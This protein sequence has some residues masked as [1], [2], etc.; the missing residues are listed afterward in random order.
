MFG[1]QR[2]IHAYQQ[3]LLKLEKYQGQ[4]DTI[5]PSHGSFPVY[6]DL[7]TKLYYGVENILAGKIKPE[8]MIIHNIPVIKYDIKVASFLMD[9]GDIKEK[10]DV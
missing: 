2:E 10:S 6:P 8:Y 5:Y 1:I 7:I 4:F 9:K 3:S